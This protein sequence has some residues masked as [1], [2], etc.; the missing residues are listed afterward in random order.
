LSLIPGAHEGYITWEQFERIQQMASENFRGPGRGGAVKIG[1]GLL[2][3]LLRCRR[4]GRKL[5]VNYTGGKH[6]F[7]RYEC[8]RGAWDNGEPRCIGF[9]G[10][11]A[12]D[13][14]AGE[15]VRVVQ[16][17][18]IEAAL[19]AGGERARRQDEA[20]AALARDLEAAR[21]AAQRA[22]RQYDAA[23]PDNRLVAGELER[24]W[25]LALQR[26][27]ELE[28]RVEEE[29]ARSRQSIP[30]SREDFEALANDLEVVWNHPETDNRLKKRIVR[31]LIHEII[32][33]V[34]A[35]ASE[36]VLIV[37]WKGGIHTELRLHRR[38][39]GQSGSQ[40][41]ESIIE[42]VRVLA[43]VCPDDM[44]ASLLNR[45]GHLTGRGNRWT[46]ER[47]VS[48]R[49]G[50]DIPCYRPETRAAEGWMNLTEAARYLG[51]SARTLRLAVERGEIEAGHPLGVG[52]WVFNRRALDTETASQLVER[53]RRRGEPPAIPNPRQTSLDFSTT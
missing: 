26:V 32:A 40:T 27:R 30:P 29:T 4:C 7:L 46:R 47:V 24:R 2:A 9:A 16:P 15:V 28:L 25:N 45:N 8:R 50:H 49:N 41:A 18:A 23:D 37:H 6:T 11:M 1:A 12:D 33:D 53:A 52:P 3:G 13:A 5:M 14:V 17:A 19:L 51:L 36:V 10:R 35:E 39:R 42:A 38:R 44:I 34:D 48:M 43:R 31:T 21:Y 22:Q 20:V